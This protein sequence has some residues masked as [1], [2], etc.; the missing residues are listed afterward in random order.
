[1]ADLFA[2]NI[3][4]LSTTH[5]RYLTP[6]YPPQHHQ[7]C[8]TRQPRIPQQ[9]RNNIAATTV[10][11]YFEVESGRVLE[12]ICWPLARRFMEPAQSQILPLGEGRGKLPTIPRRQTTS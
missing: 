9:G 3:S 5:K 11:Q 8:Q 6:T 10:F 4:D 1:M 7:V 2:R 12:D